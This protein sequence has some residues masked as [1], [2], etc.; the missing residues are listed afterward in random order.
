M[1][2]SQIGYQWTPETR[3]V[4]QQQRQDF[5]KSNSSDET[6]I[7]LCIRFAFKNVEPDE[8]YEIMKNPSII[9]EN[10]M[11][12]EPISF[13]IIERIDYIFRRDGNKTYF[14]HFKQKTWNNKANSL[15]ELMV[16]GKEIEII[17]DNKGHFWKVSISKAPRPASVTE[18]TD[19]E[20]YPPA[21]FSFNKT[22]GYDGVYPEL[23]T[24]ISTEVGS[25]IKEIKKRAPKLQKCKSKN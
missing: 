1:S 16:S 6:G 2:S 17:N 9:S 13:G 15:L 18:V 8:V 4:V 14:V 11:R 12:T 5:T 22:F 20:V 21:P 3:T 25:E 23:D 24:T 19:Y 10:G 7:S